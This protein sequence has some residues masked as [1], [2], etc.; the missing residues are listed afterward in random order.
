M[1]KETRSSSMSINGDW[2]P[3]IRVWS[4]DSQTGLDQGFD[5]NASHTQIAPHPSAAVLL[6]DA[7]CEGSYCVHCRD[8]VP[9]CVRTR[10]GLCCGAVHSWIRGLDSTQVRLKAFK[11]MS[12]NWAEPR[13]ANLG[14]IAIYGFGRRGS[15][16]AAS[17]LWRPPR[18]WAG[19]PEEFE[20]DAAQLTDHSMFS[21][22]KAKGALRDS[23]S[24]MD[25]PPKL[26]TA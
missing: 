13:S 10:R 14:D 2:I 20:D 26:A 17:L 19:G 5:L 24:Q 16:W 22:N 3:S 4:N 6:C 11:M 23:Q 12:V 1:A 25:P 21:S 15:A 18:R 9:H 8:C 7:L